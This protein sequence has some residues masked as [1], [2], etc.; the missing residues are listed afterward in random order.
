MGR[1]YKGWSLICLILGAFVL[2]GLGCPKKAIY[3]I[4]GYGWGAHFMDKD[5]YIATD[6]VN[7][8]NTQYNLANSLIGTPAK[9]VAYEPD[10]QDPKPYDCGGCHTTGFTKEGDSP[11]SDY[12][13]SGTCIGCHSVS[14]GDIVRAYQESGHQYML[15]AV[16]GGPPTLPF[17][18]VPEPPEKF[19]WDTTPGNSDLFSLPGIQ[20]QWKE[21]NIGC[22][23]CHGPGAEHAA[24]T[25]KKPSLD[26]A[27][28]ACS[29]CHIMGTPV[30]G[31]EKADGIIEADGNLIT[32]R[33]E[34]EEWNASPH[35]T[36][37][38]PDCS[39][40]HNPHATT[41]YGDTA[42]ID[43]RRVYKNEDCTTSNCH[44]GV[45]IGFNMTNLM[46][47]DCHMPKA[48][49]LAVSRLIIGKEGNY[50]YVGDI[51]SHQ[52]KINAAADSANAF[53]NT[54]RSAVQLDSNGK[55]PGLT[56]NF[57]CAQCHS[58]GGIMPHGLPA[59]TEYSFDELKTFAP[60]VHAKQ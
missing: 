23:A 47:I 55:V 40:C 16:N 28:A 32:Y 25:S 12:V 56:L 10:Q 6:G 7:G 27:K 36:A 54:D 45:T 49:T 15:N 17:S 31:V 24:N 53:F 26:T 52:F 2:M 57:T 34:W 50:N 5:G 48:A 30:D 59:A 39:Y 35:N 58:K 19:T 38:G 29:K 1:K 51:R 20:G 21:R 4:G 14:H 43:G 9:F 41:I 33:Q 22:E 18:E 13:G 60:Q 8:V 37:G 3:V 46:C 11:A 42:K 44:P